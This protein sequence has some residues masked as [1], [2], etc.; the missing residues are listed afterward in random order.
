MASTA[1]SASSTLFWRNKLRSPISRL[2]QYAD[3]QQ[4]LDACI[5]SGG[6]GTVDL[7]D[8]GKAMHWRHRAYTFRKKY[9]EAVH[10]SPSPY[11]ALTFKK[12]G[13]TEAFVRIARM[14]YVNAVFKPSNNLPA[15]Q[16]RPAV[17]EDD[18][19]LEFAKNLSTKLDGDIS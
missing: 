16:L 9:A 12:V 18:D 13:E 4:I 1:R 8:H 2:G 11:D 15:A 7:P 10:P 14:G 5:A 3:I 19:L 6:E 17:A